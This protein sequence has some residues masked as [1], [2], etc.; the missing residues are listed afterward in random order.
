MA[1]E[2][3]KKANAP[4]P[5]YQYW[6]FVPQTTLCSQKRMLSTGPASSGISTIFKT[7][8]AFSS[9]SLRLLPSDP[10]GCCCPLVASGA[11]IALFTDVVFL[12]RFIIELIELRLRIPSRCVLSSELLWPL[13]VSLVVSDHASAPAPAESSS[14]E[15]ELAATCAV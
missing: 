8:K 13:S 11:A 3:E 9:S 6:T 15:C 1:S 14:A 12:R 10:A 4:L 7:S 2:T 5:R